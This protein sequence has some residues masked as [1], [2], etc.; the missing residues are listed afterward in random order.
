MSTFPWA[1]VMGSG[2]Y[3]LIYIH[4]E[5]HTITTLLYKPLL[6]LLPRYTET[7]RCQHISAIHDIKT[8]YVSYGRQCILCNNMPK[9]YFC[10]CK[11]CCKG[12]LKEVSRSTYQRHAS[13]QV[14]LVA[15]ASD[16]R[17]GPSINPGFSF[18]TQ[19]PASGPQRTHRRANV[20]GMGVATPV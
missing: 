10:D 19:E 17:D 20:S 2:H 6:G 11:K 16:A 7:H 4:R 12:R 14:P 15:A 8:L 3:I 1:V 9:Q 18:T 13:F 5:L